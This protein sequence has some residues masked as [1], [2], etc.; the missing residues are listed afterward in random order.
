ML[1]NISFL[2]HATIKIT[3]S[4]TVYTDPY[5][6]GRGERADLILITHS[7]YDHLS[8]DDIEKI[9][10]ENTTVVASKD[11]LDILH[12][13]AAEVVGLDPYGKTTLGDVLVEAYPSY[14]VDKEF[15]PRENNW[16]SYVLTLDGTRYYIPGDTDKIPEMQDIHADIGFFPVGGTYTMDYREAAEAAKIINPRVAIPIHFG[17]IVGSDQDARKFVELVGESGHLLP[18]VSGR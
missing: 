10:D 6:I 14:N 13:I 9:A 2:G 11:C 5:K 7:H 1:D 15:H 17:S 4:R 8:L 18:A 12:G 3:G 16:N